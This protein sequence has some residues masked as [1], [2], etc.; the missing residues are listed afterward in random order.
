MFRHFASDDVKIR[1]LLED[2]MLQAEL[3][4]Y[5]EY[6]MRFRY[7]LIPGIWQSTE[8]LLLSTAACTPTYGS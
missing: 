3:S 7:R 1:T 4:G 2:R 6:A 5:R 8:V